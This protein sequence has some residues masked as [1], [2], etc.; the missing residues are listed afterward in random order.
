MGPLVR[1]GVWGEEQVWN[2]VVESIVITTACTINMH[3]FP[4]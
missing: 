4:L 2:I 3:V 1:G